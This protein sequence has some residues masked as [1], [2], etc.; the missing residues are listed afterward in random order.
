ME[1]SWSAYRYRYDA[2]RKK[3]Y[4]TV[5]L[6]VEETD[7]QPRTGTPTRSADHMVGIRIGYGEADLRQKVKEAGAIWR[8]QQK[9]RELR[10]DQAPALGLTTR[11]I[12]GQ[13]ST[14]RYLHMRRIRT[15]VE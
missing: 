15:G 14:A 4:K 5:E 1:A 7:W 9:L 13:I 6:I 8:P 3:R 10:Y 2:Q 12:S 11:I